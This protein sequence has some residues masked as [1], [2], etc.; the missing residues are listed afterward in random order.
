[1]KKLKDEISL[2]FVTNIAAKLLKNEDYEEAAKQALELI[3]ACE[4]ERILFF[5]DS[6][7]WMQQMRDGCLASLD[8]LKRPP[9]ELIPWKK[10]VKIITAKTT[11]TDATEAFRRASSEV[12]RK[13]FEAAGCNSDEETCKGAANNVIAKFRESGISVEEMEQLQ[14]QYGRLP[15]RGKRKKSQKSL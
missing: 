5:V 15:R 1:M 2:E 7:E 9:S 13:V 11:E 12:F 14:R 3:K 8:E 6:I 10:A 4:N